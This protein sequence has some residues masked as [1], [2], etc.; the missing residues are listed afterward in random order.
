MVGVNLTAAVRISSI[1]MFLVITQL[2]MMVGH[3]PCGGRGRVF[4][5]WGGGGYPIGR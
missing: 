2:K 4:G 3:E 5:D 1:M